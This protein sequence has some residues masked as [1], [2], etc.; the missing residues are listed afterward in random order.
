MNHEPLN[1]QSNQGH[2]VG[3]PPMPQGMPSGQYPAQGMPPRAMQSPM[4]STG[5]YLQQRPPMPQGMPG[6][7]YPAQ[8]MPPRTP[9]QQR[10]P[11]QFNHGQLQGVPAPTPQKSNRKI[12]AIIAVIVVALVCVIAFFWFKGSGIPNSTGRTYTSDQLQELANKSSKIQ[13]L[14]KS[15]IMDQVNNLEDLLDKSKDIEF[16]KSSDISVLKEIVKKELEPIKLLGV[17]NTGNDTLILLGEPGVNLE[18]K[19]SASVLDPAKF[20]A[21]HK[22]DF[23]GKIKLR[24]VPQ[25]F[26]AVLGIETLEK[27][28]SNIKI[29]EVKELKTKSGY[30][31]SQYTYE[32]K[33]PAGFGPESGE[34]FKF[35]LWFLQVDNIAFISCDSDSWSRKDKDPR[36]EFEAAI[37]EVLKQL[38]D[39]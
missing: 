5:Q 16:S 24:Y 14:D 39:K 15:L 9:Y 36:A 26:P 21:R 12:I 7:Q 35:E 29:K 11:A 38:K 25:D 31:Y 32:F 18:K 30:K 33:V 17:D 3:R 1:P 13:V 34:K 27:I 2:P 22:N 4:P 37:D 19:Y 28:F 6:G 20:F 8:G 23:K 10:P